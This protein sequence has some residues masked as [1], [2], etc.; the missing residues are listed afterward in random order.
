MVLHARLVEQYVACEQVALEHSAPVIG[1]RRGGDGEVRAQRVHQR[2]GYRADVAFGRAVKGGAVLEIELRHT[3]R[4]Q[5]AQG[6]Q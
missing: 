1:E 3:L 6:G 2:L 5:P 4:L